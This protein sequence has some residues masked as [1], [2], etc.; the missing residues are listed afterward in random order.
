MDYMEN[1]EVETLA[2]LAA[3]ANLLKPEEVGLD[4]FVDGPDFGGDA[5]ANTKD[6]MA[7]NDTHLLVNRYEH[8]FEIVPRFTYEVRGAKDTGFGGDYSC[9]EDFI[10]LQAINRDDA[11]AEC[12]LLQNK[13]DA[14]HLTHKGAN[15]SF[16]NAPCYVSN[17]YEI[18]HMGEV[19]Q[20]EI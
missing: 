5:P 4:F 8:G 12:E 18:D 13:H 9:Y 17:L 19:Q 14:E 16:D 7:F 2:D 11:V 10:E 6:V 3:L 1:F 20:V 15:D